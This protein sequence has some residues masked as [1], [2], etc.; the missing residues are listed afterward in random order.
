MDS[1]NRLTAIII[2]LSA[3]LLAVIGGIFFWMMASEEKIVVSDIRLNESLENESE[4]ISMNEEAATI[5]LNFSS[6]AGI[7]TSAEMN[8][9]NNLPTQNP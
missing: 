1:Y 3:I 7:D 8:P 9:S 2:I 4:S 6:N 5:P